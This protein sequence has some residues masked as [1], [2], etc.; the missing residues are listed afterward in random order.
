MVLDEQDVFFPPTTPAR[1]ITSLFNK[2]TEFFSV[3][4]IFLSSNVSNSSFV[5]NSLK[6]KF[7]LILVES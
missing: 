1:F 2:K 5:S 7:P 6:T 4:L 3:K